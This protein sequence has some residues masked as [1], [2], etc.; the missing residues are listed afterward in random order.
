MCTLSRDD[1][2]RL[3]Y[4][5]FDFPSGPFARPLAPSL[6]PHHHNMLSS[7]VLLSAALVFTLTTASATQSPLLAQPAPDAPSPFLANAQPSLADL[8]TRHPRASIF[9]EYARDS[10]S[11]SSILSEP[12]IIGRGSKHT[13][14]VPLNS[15]IL[16]LARKPHMGPAPVQQGRIEQQLTGSED[17]EQEQARAAFLERWVQLH[18]VK[19]E[20]DLDE[21]GWEGQQW[22]S[23]LKE[24]SIGFER[25]GDAG[26]R[27][28]QAD[29]GAEIVG[30]QQVS[31]RHSVVTRYGAC[32]LIIWPV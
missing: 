5:S 32:L 25:S 12:W 26:R 24:R 9:Y 28:K 14:L 10:S 19:G 16:S 4:R 2:V 13:L 27:V 1:S 11:V 23:M 8:L 7:R 17:K 31:F 21:E 22:E 15:A 29:G 20:V 6:C 30:V 3:E 18:V